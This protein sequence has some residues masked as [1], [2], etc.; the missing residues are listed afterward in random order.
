MKLTDEHKR[1]ISLAQMGKRHTAASK[2]KQSK[3]KMGN[4]NGL[5]VTPKQH[6]KIFELRSVGKN[7]QEI[8]LILSLS[9]A[10]VYNWSLRPLS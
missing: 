1:K 8:A 9:Q 6:A 2:E 10:T 3:A 4:K 5:K 7:A